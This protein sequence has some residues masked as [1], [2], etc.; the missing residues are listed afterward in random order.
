MRNYFPMRN[1]RLLHKYLPLFINDKDEK[2]R[3]L[4]CHSHK[5]N[6]EFHLFFIL[7]TLVFI[8]SVRLHDRRREIAVNFQGL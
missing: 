5:Q 4:F 3:L 1:Y 2:R 7:F 8:R 6:F